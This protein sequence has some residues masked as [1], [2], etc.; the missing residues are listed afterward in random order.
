MNLFTATAIFLF[1]LRTICFF[2]S[3]L[4]VLM[5]LKGLGDFSLSSFSDDSPLYILTCSNLMTNLSFS[6][7]ASKRSLESS[8]CYRSHT[9]TP[10]VSYLR[11]ESSS[12]HHC[13]KPFLVIYSQVIHST[14]AF[15]KYSKLLEFNSFLKWT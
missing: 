1:Q 15:S 11:Y 10:L 12:L 13:F 6:I 14:G 9:F 2:V 8:N 5:T 4:T 7:R 3:R